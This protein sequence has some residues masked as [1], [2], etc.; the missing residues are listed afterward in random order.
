MIFKNNK[1]FKKMKA[2]IKTILIF[3]C[4]NLNAQTDTLFTRLEKIPCTVKQIGTETIS[5]SYPN[6]ELVNTISKRD[7]KKIT[8]K[9]GRE[10]V[11][12]ELSSYKTI[13]G[14]NDYKNVTVTISSNDVNGLFQIANLTSKE[15]AG[16][17]FAN[18][19]KIK[20]KAIDKLRIKAAM[21]GANYIYYQENRTTGYS[22]SNQ[23]YTTYLEGV[24]YSNI[25]PDFNSFKKK[26]NNK[27][28]F[29][30]S[31]IITYNGKSEMYDKKNFSN[32]FEII[33]IQDKEGFIEVEIK[34]N[35]K[36]EY[37]KVI[38]FN[39]E[40]FI[41]MKSDNKKITNIKASF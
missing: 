18:M 23:G 20:Q 9:S 37:Y 38:S 33:N 12:N 35:K 28:E 15:Q 29:N 16:T 34:L 41:L 24:A 36:I 8:F 2:I 13:H 19:E 3:N 1:Q 6:E 40:T 10:Q 25:L 27:K 7:V 31:E 26:I 4:I 21:M 32:K 5:Y 11:F 30:T 14:A 17:I 22:A 39:N